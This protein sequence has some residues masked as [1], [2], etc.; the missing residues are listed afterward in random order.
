MYSTRKDD[1][2]VA[3]WC[4]CNAIGCLVPIA[5]QSICH[6]VLGS[7]LDGALGGCEYWSGGAEENDWKK[8]RASEGVGAGN[9]VV[10]TL[11]SYS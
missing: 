9:S 11:G 10:L 3:M 1:D 4:A 7:G 8:E 5:V 6:G 2:K